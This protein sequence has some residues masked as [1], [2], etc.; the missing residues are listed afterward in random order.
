VSKYKWFN[1]EKNTKGENN[2]RRPD[3]GDN[4]NEAKA[5][6]TEWVK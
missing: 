5:S 6:Y 1:T 2:E 3:M 4:E